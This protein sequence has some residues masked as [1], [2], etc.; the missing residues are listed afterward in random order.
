MSSAPLS[1]SQVRDC[2]RGVNDPEIGRS[3]VDLGMLKGV[4]TS[5]DGGTA[6][7]IKLPTPGLPCARTYCRTRQ[8]G[9]LSADSREWFRNG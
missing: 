9:H 8:G 1:E 7:T 3:L 2:L 4:R 5:S 6:V